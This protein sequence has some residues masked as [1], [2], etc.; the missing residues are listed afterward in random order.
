MNRSILSLLLKGVLILSLLLGGQAAQAQG[1]FFPAEMNKSFSPISIVPGGISR[2]RVTIYNP[3]AFPLSQAAWTDNLIGVQPGLSIANPVNLTNSCGG[4]VTATA[5]TTTL[6]LSGGIVPA[7]VGTAPG[8]CTVA[9]DVT[10]TTPGNLINTIPANALSSTGAGSTI[11]NTTPASATLHVSAVQAPALSK[12]FSPTTILIGEISR[13]TISIRNTDLLSALTGASLS[14]QL[15]ANVVLANPVS[16][17]LSNC[18]TSASLAATPG[19]STLTL[20]NADIAA[21]TACTIRVNVTSTV[22]DVYTN[23]IPAGALD[24]QQGLTNTAPATATLN[25]QAVRV[26]KVF[27]PATLQAGGTT[28][29][30]ITLENPSSV[31]YTGV[32]VSDTLP[33]TVLTV[34][35]GSAAT[36]CGGTAST[37]PPRTVSLTGGTI[38]AG[39]AANPGSCT[40]TVQVTAPANAS[41]GTFTNTIPAGMLVTDQGVT[42]LAPATARVRV[43]PPGGGIAGNKSF[44]PATIPAGG[45]SR[46]RINITAPG[47]SDLTNFSIT[48]QLPPNVTV[49]NSSP[50][51]ASPSCGASAVL[52]ATTGATSIS[53]TNGTIAAGT[54]CQ[55]TVYVTSS[56]PGVHTNTIQPGDITNNENRTV[57][58][59][60]TADLAVEAPTDFSIS[61]AFTPPNVRPG[62]ISTLTITLQNANASPLVS[63]SLTD[64]LPGTATSGVIIAPT[65]NASTTCAGGV[66]TAVPGTQMVS[67]T[68]GTVPAQAGNVPGTC[69]I[70]VDV[71]GLGSLTTRTNTIPTANASATIQGTTTTINPGQSASADLTIG[72]LAVA[73]VKGFNP[74]TVFGGSAS[75]LSIQLFNPNNVTLSGI[76]FT[77]NMPSGMIIANPANLSVGNC[78]GTLTGAPG[79]DSFSLTNASLQAGASCT[80]TL[81]VT[82]TVNGNLTNIIPANAVTTLNGVTNPDP[83]EATLTNL[84]G[85]S[86]NKFF[87]PNPVAAG[88]AALLTITIQDTGGI[89]LTGMGLIDSLPAGVELLNSP[90]PINTCGGTLTAAAGTQTIQLAGGTLTANSSCTI[91]VAVAGATPGSYANTLAPNNLMNDQGVTNSQAATDTLVVISGTVSGGTGGG[92]ANSSDDDNGN[93]ITNIGTSAPLIPLTGFPPNMYTPLKP[94]LNSPYA[95]TTLT[96]EIPVLDVEATIMGVE[97]KAGRWDVS[98]LQDQ[99]GWLNGT[100]YPTLEGN[101]LLT[102]HVI[103]ADGKPGPF[104]HLKRLGV[105]EYM[106]VHNGGYRYTYQVVSNTVVQPND[107]SVFQH[108]EHSYLT[109]ITC[110][111]YD[112]ATRT[113]LRRV[114]VRAKLVDVRAVE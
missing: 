31:P 83:A 16:P 40:I 49:S 33:G 91:A 77:D 17:A 81:S 92:G 23:T 59:N 15:P 100:A 93:V 90:A 46:L 73:V 26:R 58:N 95:V 41:A 54:N 39:T 78:G 42:N 104:F 50:A 37:S 4:N 84:P 6:S 7:R 2:L 1:P 98:W 64:N 112:E 56:T 114:A 107:A 80:L 55:I 109:L 87:S 10:S 12:N 36:T 61:K 14:D 53:L 89:S 102:A 35:A 67:M 69:T 51:T 9:V 75:T 65:P 8:S 103:K 30:T 110:D 74:L 25:V 32:V 72:N 5:G 29:L 21:D 18:G 48:D 47:D 113:F 11:T 57:P 24:N 43:F 99:I 28:T 38:P 94:I 27:S 20:N 79:A 85:A 44:S 82:I 97:K 22:S 96:L 70:A 105:G 66:V 111:G 101:S 68:G 3:N 52:T 71:Q 108:E 19:A 45:N 63:A 13:L 76:T 88:E 60:L 62:G 34:V 86:L 106:F